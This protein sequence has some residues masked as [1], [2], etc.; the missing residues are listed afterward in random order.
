MREFVKGWKRK[1]GRVALVVI[2]V[3]VVAW[4]R[5]MVCYDDMKFAHGKVALGVSSMG[6]YLGVFRCTFDRDLEWTF[7]PGIGRDLDTDPN[8]GRPI[9]PWSAGHES[10]W[11]WDCAGVHVW[12][13]H[14]ANCRFEE[15]TIS[16]AYIIL[17][18]TLLSAYLLLSKSRPATP[19]VTQPGQPS[20]V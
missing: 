15:F 2:S 12:E 3:F 7:R 5:S 4:I 18:L 9:S 20:S 8:R 14:S 19:T 16:D 1:I 13:S 6:G 17:P 11:R 10:D